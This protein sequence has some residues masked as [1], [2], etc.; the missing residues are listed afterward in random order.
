MG[1]TSAKSA[2]VTS[3]TM[4]ATRPRSTTEARGDLEHHPVSFKSMDGIAA[5]APPPKVG[6][7]TLPQPP[8]AEMTEQYINRLEEYLEAVHQNPCKF[9]AH[10]QLARVRMDAIARLRMHTKLRMDIRTALGTTDRTRVSL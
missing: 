7:V 1:C 6:N 2:T 8:D 3:T 9:A 10:V 4:A 5:A